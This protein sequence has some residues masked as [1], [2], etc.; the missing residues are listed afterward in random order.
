MN[1]ASLQPGISIVIWTVGQ[2]GRKA[3]VGCTLVWYTVDVAAPRLA[4]SKR[5]HAMHIFLG[6]SGLL[7]ANA[8]EPGKYY[9]KH[10]GTSPC[11][12][13]WSGNRQHAPNYPVHTPTGVVPALKTTFGNIGNNRLDVR[14]EPTAKHLSTSEDQPVQ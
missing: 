12:H 14:S 9:N 4:S 11:Q 7:L 10:R 3:R 8:D 13:C 1:L 5:K 2:K 6:A